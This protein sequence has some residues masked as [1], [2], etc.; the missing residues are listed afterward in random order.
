[1]IFIQLAA[2]AHALVIAVAF[3]FIHAE[4]AHELVQ[5][6]TV[7]RVLIIVILIVGLICFRVIGL[8]F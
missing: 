4:F 5:C 3:S 8:G 2:H 6:L 1:M 7:Q